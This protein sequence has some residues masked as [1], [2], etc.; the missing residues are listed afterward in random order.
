MIKNILFDFDGVLL[1]SVNAKAEAFRKLYLPYGE[2]IA[3][4]VVEHH[5]A[6]GGVSRFEKIKYWHKHYLG[7]ELSQNE[8][9]ELADKFSELVMQNVINSQE[10]EGASPFLE[11][12]YHDFQFWI[13]SA[14][15][16]DEIRKILD[17]KKWS[18][19]F[20][21]AYGSPESKTYWTNKVVH[22]NGLDNNETIFI[23]DATTDYEA[24]SKAG[25]NFILRRTSENN[26]VFKDY[27]GYSIKNIAE[28]EPVLNDL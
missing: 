7:I 1:E 21:Q 28:L 13:I 22:D 23:G 15:P 3:N 25:I 8:V 2:D 4:K 17:E 9:N 5:L 27:K 6:N 10:V 16:T 19:F 24:A 26:K 14:T 18:R 20:K 11:K 12:H